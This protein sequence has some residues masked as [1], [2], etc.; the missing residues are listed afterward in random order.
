ME[1]DRIQERATKFSNYKFE[2]KIIFPHGKARLTIMIKD[3]IRYQRL[4]EFE[5]NENPFLSIL[6]KEKCGKKL[7]ISGLYRQ[8]KAPGETE[9]STQEGISRQCRRLER[10][11]ENLRRISDMKYEHILGGDVNIDR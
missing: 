7:R 2:D 9:S 4:I 10:V 1:N 8:W 3:D 6:I 5:D 11:T